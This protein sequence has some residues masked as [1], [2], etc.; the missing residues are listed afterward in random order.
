MNIVIVGGSS[1]S[2]ALSKH[3]LIKIT[4]LLVLEILGK[5]LAV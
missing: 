3:F 1:E 5:L 2:Q 4:F